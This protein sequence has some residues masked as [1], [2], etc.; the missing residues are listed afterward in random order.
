MRIDKITFL[1]LILIL[2]LLLFQ[3]RLWFEADGL[4]GVFRLKKQLALQMKEN[5]KLK[6]RNEVLRKQVEY[7]Q[8]SN[9][10]VESRARQEL[11]MIKTG[12]TFYH[13]V[14]QKK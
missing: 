2:F 1:S 10:A 14:Q 6:Q 3:Y 9:N 11:G 5:D 8:A 7:L 12:E 13:V 4:I